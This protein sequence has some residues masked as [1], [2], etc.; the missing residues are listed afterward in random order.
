MAVSLEKTQTARQARRKQTGEDFTPAELVNEMLDQFPKEIWLDADKTWLDPTAGNG[1]FL[2][3]VYKR[4][5]AAGHSKD[6]ILSNMIFGA[7]L[8]DDNCQEMIFRLYGEGVIKRIPYSKMPVAYK[9]KGMAYVYMH[10]DK[11]VHNIVCANGL[12]YNYSF[13][14]EVEPVQA[15]FDWQKTVA[16]NSVSLIIALTVKKIH[17]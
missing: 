16:F 11:L 1:N 15:L 17:S 7:D 13:G 2:V 3:E 12:E 8:M 10:N 14:R 6:H 5:I 9:S 4:L